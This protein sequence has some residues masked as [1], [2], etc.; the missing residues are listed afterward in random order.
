MYIFYVNVNT[1][2]YYVT[3]TCV[4]YVYLHANICVLKDRYIHTTK[5]DQ[6]LMT[7]L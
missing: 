3:L 6:K 2:R 4:T 7:H 5:T 1:F